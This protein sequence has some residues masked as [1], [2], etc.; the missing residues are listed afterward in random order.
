M[1]YLQ[2]ISGSSIKFVVEIHYSK[3]RFNS[4]HERKSIAYDRFNIHFFL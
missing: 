1:Y 4:W 3:V 2:Y